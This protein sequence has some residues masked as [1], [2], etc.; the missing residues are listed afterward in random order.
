MQ[1]ELDKQTKL[2]INNIEKKINYFHT[3]IKIVL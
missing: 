2:Y 1:L 3:F